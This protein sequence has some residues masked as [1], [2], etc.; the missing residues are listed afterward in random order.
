MK[1]LTM[2][3]VVALFALIVRPA[4]A[5]LKVGDEA[6]DFS[7][8]GSDGQTYKLS[9]YKGKQA[10]VLAW[11]PRAFT[12][13]CTAECKSMAENSNALHKFDVAYFTVSTDTLD[14][15]KG[16]KAFADSLKA[17]YPILSDPDGSTAKAYGVYNESRNFASR[18][19]F[20][21]DRDGKIAAIDD[22]ID[23]KNAGADIV[24]KLKQLGVPEKP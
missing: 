21:I 7:L 11:F 23:T 24:N 16:N 9:D 15:E 3:A 5:E 13:G 1:S 10:V 12:G 22:K 17:D 19:T 14:G 8:Q 6:P 2:L 20:Y 18:V 4:A